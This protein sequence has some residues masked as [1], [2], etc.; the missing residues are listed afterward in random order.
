MFASRRLDRT[1]APPGS[2]PRHVLQHPTAPYIY[3]IHEMGQFVSAFEQ[4]PGR[5]SLRLL[6]SHSLVLEH[7]IR[8]AD[9]SWPAPY[10]KAAEIAITRDGAHLYATNRGIDADGPGQADVEARNAPGYRGT[11]DTVD[12]FDVRPDGRLAARQRV[13]VPQWPRGMALVRGDRYLL[14][15]EQTTGSVA[16]YAVAPNG[17]LSA[18]GFSAI[19]MPHTASLGVLELPARTSSPAQIAPFAEA[20]LSARWPAAGG[21]PLVAVLLALV[22]W[23]RSGRRRGGSVYKGALL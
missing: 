14:V 9:G 8:A 12:V 10:A 2:G 19:G 21:W 3:V 4:M 17:T 6:S 7:G 16:S 20:S 22:G 18:T 13:L 23:G 1:P 5:P 15:A 11:V